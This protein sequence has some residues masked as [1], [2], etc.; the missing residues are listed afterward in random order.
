M[1]LMPIDQLQ[2]LSRE[3]HYGCACRTLPALLEWFTP[4]ERERLQSYG[5]YPVKLQADIAVA[6]SSWQVLIGRR[7]PFVDGATRIRWVKPEIHA[8]LVHRDEHAA[9]GHLW[10]LP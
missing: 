10:R 7:R 4:I 1:D 5:Y 9:F 6:E 8:D 2:A 3:F